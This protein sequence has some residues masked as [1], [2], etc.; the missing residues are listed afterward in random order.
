[1]GGRMS[2]GK[3]NGVLAT[4]AATSRQK[5]RWGTDEREGGLNEEGEEGNNHRVTTLRQ[6][7]ITPCTMTTVQ[8]IKVSASL[9]SN[10]A[11]G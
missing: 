9:L 5:G 7:P 2:G 10:N 11:L 3:K 1:M 4:T 6:L 8:K